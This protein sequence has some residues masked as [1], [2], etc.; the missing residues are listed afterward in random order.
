MRI[1][2]GR[3]RGRKFNPP[4]DSW[5]TR[6]TM[7]VAREGLFNVLAN[8]YDFESI[9]VLELFGG[10]GAISL[11]FISRG[12]QQ[13]LW[14]EKHSGCIRFLKDVSVK[15]DLH[16]QLRIVPGDALKFL[17]SCDQRFDIIV[18]DPPYNYPKYGQLVS[19]VFEKNILKPDGML[20]LEHESDHDF[21][22]HPH[23][24][25]KKNYGNSHFS[26]FAATSPG[27]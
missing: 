13:V 26:F 18:G 16:D 8:R 4:L 12:C 3:F 27:E 2:S 15:L 22:N 19:T 20:I 24:S 17:K 7:D 25:F 6:P 23:F 14:V 10:T 5:P 11:E 21:N 9:S 1:I